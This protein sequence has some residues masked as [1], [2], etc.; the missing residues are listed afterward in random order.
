M[1][2]KTKRTLRKMTPLSRELAKL[3]NEADRI[4]RW[5]HRLS[6][7]VAEAEHKAQSLDAY[8]V[9]VDGQEEAPA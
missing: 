4:A 5:A 9:F 1:P 6:A 8:M 2:T 7:K 3:G